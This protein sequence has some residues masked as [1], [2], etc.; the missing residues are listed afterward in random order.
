MKKANW[1]IYHSK[2]GGNRLISNHFFIV[3]TEAK[4]FIGYGEANTL[5]YELILKIIANSLERYPYPKAIYGTKHFI[6]EV[7]AAFREI[8][9]KDIANFPKKQKRTIDLWVSDIVVG[10]FEKLNP[11]TIVY[12]ELE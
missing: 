3:D 4:R 1:M 11:G 5:N 12:L 7:P 8:N 6:K 9:F 2:T 10:E